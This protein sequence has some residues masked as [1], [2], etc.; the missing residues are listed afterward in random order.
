LNPRKI[1]ITGAAG[2]IGSHVAEHLALVYPQAQFLYFDKMTYAAHYDN[3]KHLLENGSRRLVVA[4]LCDLEAC[5][6][7]TR[8]ADL[9]VHLAAESHVDLSFGNSLLFT[10][11][12]V[13]GTHTLLEACRVNEI[14]RFVHV[15]TD[16]VYGEVLEGEAVEVSP[17]CPTNPYSA[18]KAG[19]EMAVRSY[20][21]SYKMPIVVVRANNI[22]GIRQFPEKIIPK[23][24]MNLMAGRKLPLHGHGQYKRHYLAAQD[25]AKAIHLLIESGKEGEAYNVGTNVEHSNVEIAQMI[26][27]LMNKDFGECAEFVTDR[28]FNDG[29]YAVATDKIRDLGWKPERDLD[30]ELPGIVQWY[31]THAGRYPEF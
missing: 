22:Y 17:L 1:V 20:V 10:R 8:G 6:K 3:I 15:S 31:C 23:F 9:V 29:R 30:V 16:E 28:P 13:V 18:S 12:N 7:A 24:T 2:F 26:C 11:T 27:T 4:D 25:F 19:A 5:T 21:L 14:S